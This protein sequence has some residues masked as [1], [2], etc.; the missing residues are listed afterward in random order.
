MIVKNHR[1]FHSLYSEVMC[2]RIS[3][4]KIWEVPCR[5]LKEVSTLQRCTKLSVLKKIVFVISLQTTLW[6][7]APC[8][9]PYEKGF[10]T[11]VASAIFLANDELYLIYLPLS[12]PLISM[13]FV[14]KMKN[15]IQTSSPSILIFIKQY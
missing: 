10:E 11:S 14:L 9:S 8:I 2:S 1:N 5:F 3:Q 12:F 4:K 15:Y 13:L 6:T 7:S